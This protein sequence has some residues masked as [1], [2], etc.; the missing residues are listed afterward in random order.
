MKELGVLLLS[1]WLIL[2]GLHG[3]IGLNFRNDDVIYG[4]LAIVAGVLLLM[5][6]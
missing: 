2:Q 1:V 6:R 3:A 5:K 4:V